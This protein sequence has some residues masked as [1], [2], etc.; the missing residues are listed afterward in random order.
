MTTTIGPVA[1]GSMEDEGPLFFNEPRRRSSVID[2]GDA[3]R[4]IESKRNP[5]PASLITGGGDTHILKTAEG[6]KLKGKAKVKKGSAGKNLA[7]EAKKKKKGSFGE[8][9]EAVSAP[10][11]GE[12]VKESNRV[13]RC[14]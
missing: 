4:F 3:T 1:N 10:K 2:H 8:V 6:K 12:R 9:Y 5:S 14:L 13:A 7:K 11:K